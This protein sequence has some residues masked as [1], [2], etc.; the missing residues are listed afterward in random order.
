VEIIPVWNK[1]NREHG[2]LGSKP[3]VKP[4]FLTD[5]ASASGP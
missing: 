4:I 5:N 3:D 1:S 2:M